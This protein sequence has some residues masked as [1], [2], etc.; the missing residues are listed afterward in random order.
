MSGH[1]HA[2][3]I[4]HQKAAT[5]QKR[6]RIFSKM[7]RL[8]A[9]AVKDGG[10]NLETN[11]K[12]KTALER[13]RS[14]NMPNDNIDRAIKQALG[15]QEGKTLSEFSF[16]AYGPGGIT[17]IIDGITDNKNRALGEIKQI[18]SQHNGKLVQEGAVR[19]MFD[20]KGVIVVNPD[21][22]DREKLELIA[23]EAG[24][25]D[26]AWQENFL[27]VYT[28]A[29]NLQTTKETLASQGLR[30]ESATLDWTAKTDVPLQPAEK[31]QAEKLLSSLD[32][33]EDVQDVYSSLKD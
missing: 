6:G 28:A 8:I 10:A 19:W 33:N 24:A 18:L 4:A 1:S 32:E 20:R 31:A 30:I 23:I 22:Q 16:E 12:L 25:Q 17:L 14:V 26:L 29:E 7:A 15:G 9:V 27:E 21:G 5:D 2:K 11:S 13:A 3:T